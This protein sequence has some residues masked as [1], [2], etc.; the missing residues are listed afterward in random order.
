MHVVRK[1]VFSRNKD[2]E[3]GSNYIAINQENLSISKISYSMTQ[4]TLSREGEGVSTNSYGFN[5]HSLSKIAL[6]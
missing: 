5:I 2:L 6:L 4:D 3:N 1:K